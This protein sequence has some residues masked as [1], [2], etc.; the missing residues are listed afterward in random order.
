MKNFLLLF[1]LCYIGIVFSQNTTFKYYVYFTNSN[2]IPKF[3]NVNG[4][5]KY[6]GSDQIL[7]NFFTQEKKY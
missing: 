1:A 3:D 2:L 5:Y 7:I 6:T 4:I